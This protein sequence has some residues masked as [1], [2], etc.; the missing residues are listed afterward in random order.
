MQGTR[1]SLYSDNKRFLLMKN[2]QKLES[3]EE[4]LKTEEDNDPQRLLRSLLAGR[5][6]LSLSL[7]LCCGK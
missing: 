6:E 3:L 2:L 4:K 5:I 7:S 1:S